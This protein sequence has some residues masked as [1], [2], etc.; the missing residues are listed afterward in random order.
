MSLLVDELI[1][2]GGVGFYLGFTA[3]RQ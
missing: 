2:S 1:P 3:Q